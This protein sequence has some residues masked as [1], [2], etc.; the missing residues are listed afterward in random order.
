M[1]N[2]TKDIIKKVIYYL[3]I[4]AIVIYAV[5]WA[6]ESLQLRDIGD[7]KILSLLASLFVIALFCERT[8]EIIIHTLRSTGRLELEEMLQAKQDELEILNKTPK[9]ISKA[10]S[11]VED[12]LQEIKN[13]IK[14]YKR[15][16]R[17][18]SMLLGLLIGILVSAVGIRVIGALVENIPEGGIQSAGF[19]IVD[20]LITGGLISG[21]SEGIHRMMNVYNAFTEKA[22]DKLKEK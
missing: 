22:E 7:A 3:V 21:G 16:T 20:I 12:A 4:V 6:K 10:I 14:E 2:K 9:P 5:I 15:N 11:K 13:K 18:T 17:S 1:K 19:K 8:L